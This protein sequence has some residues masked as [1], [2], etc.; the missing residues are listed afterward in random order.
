[1]RKCDFADGFFTDK[2]AFSGW[3]GTAGNPATKHLYLVQYR[4]QVRGRLVPVGQGFPRVLRQFRK[5]VVVQG[6]Q[7][8]LSEELYPAG[9]FPALERRFQPL[10][11]ARFSFWR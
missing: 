10:I 9:N 6:G 5:A 7:C 1:M 11:F 3:W 8:A 4:K 2:K